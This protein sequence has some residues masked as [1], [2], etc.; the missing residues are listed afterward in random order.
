[1]TRART[2]L[3][4]A[5]VLVLLVGVAVYAAYATRSPSFDAPRPL[6][7]TAPKGL[8]SFYTQQLDWSDCKTGGHCATVK[9]PVAG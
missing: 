1:V 9:V 4:I 6:K 3:L 5:T 8:D 7:A 2:T